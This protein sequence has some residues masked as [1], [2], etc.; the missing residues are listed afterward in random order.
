MGSGK[1]RDVEASANLPGE[2][3]GYLG[4][5]RNSLDRTGCWVEPE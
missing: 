1:V 5:P 4:V 3:V 2:Q